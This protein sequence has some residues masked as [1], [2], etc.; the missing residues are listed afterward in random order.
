[1]QEF[2]VQLT[3]EHLSR[4]SKVKN[5]AALNEIIWN[6]ID[7]DADNIY[8]TF[9]YDN[10]IDPSKVTKIT[11]NDDGIGIDISKI[12]A[13]LKPYGKSE[14][15]YSNRSLKGRLYHGKLGE[16]RYTYFSLGSGIKWFS[17]FS[18]NKVIKIYRIDFESDSVKV[19]YSTPEVLNNQTTG[20]EVIISNINEDTAYDFSNLANVET[21][22]IKEFAPYFF[23]YKNM[24]IFINGKKVDFNTNISKIKQYDFTYAEKDIKLEIVQ[25]KSIKSNEVFYCGKGNVVYFHDKPDIFSNACSIYIESIIF[26]EM[27]LNGEIELLSF[28]KL[29]KEISD[30][31]INSFNSFKNENEVAINQAFFEDLKKQDIYPYMEEPTSFEEQEQKKIFDVVALQINKVAPKINNANKTTK[32]LTYNLINEAIKTNPSSLKKILGEVFK[33]SKEEQD[34][35]ANLLDETSMAAIVSTMKEV[36]DRLYFLDELNVL[37]YDEA[38]KHVKERTQFQKLLLS[39]LWIF[40]DKYKYGVDD[41]SLRN[42]LKKYIEELGLPDIELTQEDY[43]NEDYNKIPDIVL[44]RNNKFGNVYENLVVEIKRPTKV[45]GS[46]EMDQI[47]KYALAISKDGRFSKENCK[48]RF[49]LIGKDIDDYI[50]NELSSTRS[51]FIEYPTYTIEI[52]TWG[53]LITNNKLKYEY[54][55]EKS[56]I[57]PENGKVMDSLQDRWK[58]LLGDKAPTV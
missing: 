49:I 27:K 1:M 32:K 48:W 34:D 26:D 51:G 43:D 15:N 46:T 6:S 28:E 8:I 58:A 21:S 57:N 5:F 55:R 52:I 25:W 10:P 17:R 31:I 42:V 2:N 24:N 18:D 20:L 29:E 19:K 12:E 36:K 53:E 37:V 11:V 14:K 40:G 9:S 3:N 22:I 38:G 23:A 30:F 56:R 33:L 45:L 4:I 13:V 7:A 54:F 50:K 47:K 39:Q 16:G 41:V 35:F 44:W